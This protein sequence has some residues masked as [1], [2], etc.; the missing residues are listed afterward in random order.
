[1]LFACSLQCFVAVFLVGAIFDRYLLCS[2]NLIIR[3]CATQ[4]DKSHRGQGHGDIC[5]SMVH[6]HGRQYE[7]LYIAMK[8][9]MQQQ[10]HGHGTL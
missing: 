6:E 8:Y 9:F 5:Q 1:M 10:T 3:V 7:T 2:M 4:T